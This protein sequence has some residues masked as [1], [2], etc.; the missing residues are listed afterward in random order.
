MKTI[1]K[2]QV[3]YRTMPRA[4]RRKVLGIVGCKSPGGCGKGPK[5]PKWTKR[6][7]RKL[8]RETE[9][10]DRARAKKKIAE[11][12]P[13]AKRRVISENEEPGNKIK[14]P[15]P[16]YT[17]PASFELEKRIENQAKRGKKIVK[18]IVKSS[19]KLKVAKK[20]I[21]KTVKRK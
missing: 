15:G 4:E 1:K 5:A 19:S 14:R 11:L 17:N 16:D 20:G 12:P 6:D 3:G 2:A 10:W 9:E 13:I 21:K 8:D 18:K 7:Q